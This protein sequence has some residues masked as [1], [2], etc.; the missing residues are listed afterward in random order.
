MNTP[1]Y[2]QR[3]IESCLGEYGDDICDSLFGLSTCLSKKFLRSPQACEIGA[4][5][6]KKIWH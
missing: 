4:T 6:V 2:F 1:A 5:K 3:F